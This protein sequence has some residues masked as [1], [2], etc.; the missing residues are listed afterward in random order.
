MRIAYLV[1]FYPPTPCGGVGYYTANLAETFAARSSAV[2]VLCVDL[3]GE[4]P[5]YFNGFTDEVYNGVLIRRLHINWKKAP[6]PFDWLYDSP[7]L[8]EQA[9]EFF[10][11][12]RPDVVHVNSCYSLSVRP[13]IIAKELGLPVV[14]QLHDY[15]IIC[16]RHTLLH[17]DNAICSGPT[18]TW[19]CQ[20]CLLAGTKPW[21][22]TGMVMS[23]GSQQHLFETLARSDSITRLPGLRGMLGCHQERQDRI[24]NMLCGVDVLVTS[25]GFAR[26]LFVQNGVK[27]ECIKVIPYGN[28]LDWITSVS[29]PPSDRLRV[30]FLGNI[31]PIKGVHVLLDAYKILRISGHSFDLAIWGDPNVEP[32]YYASLRSESPADVVWGGKYDRANLP[33]IMSDLDIV[34]VPSLWYEV[35]PFVVQEAFAAGLPVIVSDKSSL[36]ATVQDGVTGLH[37]DMGSADDLAAQL[38][39]ILSEPDLLERLTS[40]VSPPRTLEQNA[41][42]FA[43]LYAT[44]ARRYQGRSDHPK[45]SMPDSEALTQ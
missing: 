7:V 18:S 11:Y 23:D 4:G 22:L 33:Q 38:H 12:F 29:R 31:I 25:T 43:Y 19:K 15:W 32:A 10:A 16:S 34:V 24:A 3:W 6:R 30:G 28:R 36:A 8:G 44:L 21:R 41:D 5:D 45:V 27:H 14:M 39:R 1:H 13:V 26:D 17:K 20:Q 35:Q 2:G 42:E 37:F 40:N 9:R